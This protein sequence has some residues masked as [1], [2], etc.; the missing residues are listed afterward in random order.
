MS[1]L[2]TSPTSI[3]LPVRLDGISFPLLFSSDRALLLALV[4]LCHG[5]SSEMSL[6]L[7]QVVL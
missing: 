5:F 4:P 2:E 1:Y 3:E 6:V 7:P